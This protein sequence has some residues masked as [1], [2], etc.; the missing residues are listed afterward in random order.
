MKKREIKTHRGNKL[1][2]SLR[3]LAGDRGPG[4]ASDSYS[5]S[6]IDPEHEPLPQDIWTPLRFQK[7]NPADGINGISN[8]SLLAV[9]R[10]RLE[11]FQ[12]GPF[13]CEENKH[14]LAWIISA[15]DILAARS[16]R[17]DLRGVE[18]TQ[19]P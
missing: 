9:I 1:N 17:R 14:A 12:A 13:A 11:G 3:I 8:E 10:D 15:M 2:D 4:G 7:G 19:Q 5:I 18:G 16:M 6:G